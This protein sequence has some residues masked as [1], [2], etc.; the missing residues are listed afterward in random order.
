MCCHCVRDGHRDGVGQGGRTASEAP[1]SCLGMA[2]ATHLLGLWVV[3]HRTALQDVVL[4]LIRPVLARDGSI[5]VALGVAPHHL[6]ARHKG[7]TA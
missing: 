2:T 3:H 7:T 1:P 6:Q 4:A 5:R